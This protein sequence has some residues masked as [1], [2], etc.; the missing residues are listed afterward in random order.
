MRIDKKKKNVFRTTNT[1][2]R[3]D[4]NCNL[5]IYNKFVILKWTGSEV[6]TQKKSR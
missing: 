3:N 4:E 6:I 5:Q 1:T 2:G